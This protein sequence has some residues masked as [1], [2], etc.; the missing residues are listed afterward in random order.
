MLL[1]IGFAIAPI[2]FG[3]DKF[4]GVLTDDWTRYL[5]PQ[6]NDPVLVASIDDLIAMKRAAGR[7]KDTSDVEELEAILRLRGG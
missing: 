1:R 6:F 2:L 5:A 7:A 4:A 3:L